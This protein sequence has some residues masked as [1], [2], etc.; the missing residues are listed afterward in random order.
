VDSIKVYEWAHQ[1]ASS[2]GSD[3]NKFF[4][5]GDSAGA[6]LSLAIANDLVADPP[7]APRSKAA[8]PLSWQPCIGTTYSSSKSM[9]RSYYGT[10]GVPIIDKESYGGLLQRGRS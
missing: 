4:S 6:T 8:S 5:I 7:N 10:A 3:T 1:N 9:Y 2:I